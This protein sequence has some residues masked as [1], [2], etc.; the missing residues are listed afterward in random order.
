MP[1]ADQVILT[2]EAV[3][4]SFRVPFAIVGVLALALGLFSSA[5]VV[6][7][8]LDMALGR[9][10]EGSLLIGVAI[11]LPFTVLGTAFVWVYFIPE[12][13]MVFDGAERSLTSTRRFPFGVIREMSFDLN[14]SAVPELVWERNSDATDGGYWTLT[15]EL[16]DGRMVKHRTGGQSTAEEKAAAENIRDRIAEL[17]S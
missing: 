6:V 15:F 1:A 14:R 12:E 7:A 17:V 10:V 9:P 8:L 11:A 2:N 16:P 13:V 3:S 5:Q 4:P